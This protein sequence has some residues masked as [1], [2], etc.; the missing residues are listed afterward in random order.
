MTTSRGGWNLGLCSSLEKIFRKLTRQRKACRLPGGTLQK[1]NWVG[2]DRIEQGLFL[3]VH[4]DVNVP[5][6]L[7]VAVK[8]HHPPPPG[9][10]FM[11]VSSFQ[12][13]LLLSDRG[14]I[15]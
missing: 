7:P 12:K 14:N 8:L 10:S 5:F 11:A 2:G 3:Q 13:F 1:G 15:S 4:H 9:M 6:S